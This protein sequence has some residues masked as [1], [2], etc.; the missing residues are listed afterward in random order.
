MNTWQEKLTA[1][2]KEAGASLVGCGCLTD[3]PAAREAGFSGA[4]SIGVA[5]DSAIVKALS[6]GPTLAYNEEYHRV[7]GILDRLDQLAA[8]WL[9]S[10]GFDAHPLIRDNVPVDWEALETPLPHKTAALRAGHG[11]IGRSGLIVTPEYGSAIRF[12]TVL[13]NAPVIPVPFRAD[14]CGSCLRCKEACPASAIAGVPWT[15]ALQR[16]QY[17]NAFACKAFAEESCRKLGIR[18][19]ICGICIHACPYSQKYL[20]AISDKNSVIA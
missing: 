15:Q 8:D 13:T 6:Q 14:G 1:R 12:S 7:N 5:L 16:E 20:R 3:V 9:V 10:Q 17:Y 4:V 18:N 19:D 11:W 2:I